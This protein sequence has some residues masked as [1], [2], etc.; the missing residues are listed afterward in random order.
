MRSRLCLIVLTVIFF[1]LSTGVNAQNSFTL[2]LTGAIVIGPDHQTL[3]VSVPTEGKLVYFDTVAEK[4]LKQIDVDFQ[5]NLLAIQGKLLFVSA[6]GTS[7]IHVLEW[8]TAKI[9]RGI[10]VPGEPLIS[11]GCHPEKGLLYAVNLQN[12]MFSIDP[13]SGVA[14][15]TSGKGQ[16]LAFDPS[17]SQVFYTGIQKAINEVLV[18]QDVGN[19][20]H[21]SLAQAN[22]PR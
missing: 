14:T 8:D 1:Y 13:Q 11:M 5:P 7:T 22:T 12:E 16:L 21:V 17:D 18:F 20:V 2:S 10:N 19:E 9:V 3:I 15:K 6:K 4:Q